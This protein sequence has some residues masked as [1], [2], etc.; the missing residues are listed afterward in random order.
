M[1]DLRIERKARGGDR[2]MS[3]WVLK[4]REPESTSVV[5]TNEILLVPM[6]SHEGYNPPTPIELKL[7]ARESEDTQIEQADL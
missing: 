7:I 4:S 6:P 2:K 5:R 3:G 1:Y